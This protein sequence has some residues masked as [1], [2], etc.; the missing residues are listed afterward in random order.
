MVYNEWICVQ[1]WFDAS[2]RLGPKLLLHF[3]T[4]ETFHILFLLHNKR[5]VVSCS[6][7]KDKSEFANSSLW[8]RG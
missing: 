4:S 7:L 5:K 6:T 8:G 3:F 1:P 2:A